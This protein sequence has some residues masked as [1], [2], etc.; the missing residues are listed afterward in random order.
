MSN[1]LLLVLNLIFIYFSVLV[2]YR[3]LG[4]RGLVYWTVFATIAA[5]IEVLIM[6][7][8]F[9]MHQTLGNV[10]FASTFLVTDILSEVE[11][12]EEANLAV[13]T[14]IM[15]SIFFI[16]VSQFWLMFSPSSDDFAF[17]SIKTVFSSTPRLMLAGLGV[18]AVVQ[19]IDI[20]LYHK[21]W[22]FTDKYFKDHSRGLWIRNNGSTLISQ[23]I[24]AILF[25]TL[26]FYGVWDNK[27]LATVML[28]SYLIFVATSLFDTPFVYLAKK[29]KERGKIRE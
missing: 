27:T 7:E 1:E 21:W 11:G 3:L 8:A 28:S 20:I 2:F 13:K 16:L 22:K 4:K 5:N 10:M 15:T 29:M 17:E 26:A 19:K 24:N 12:K 23:L 14:G 9:G 18:Y 25:T 6:V